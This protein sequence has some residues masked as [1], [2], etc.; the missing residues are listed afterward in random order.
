MLNSGEW[1]YE[2]PHSKQKH[3]RSLL[4]QPPQDV[5]AKAGLVVLLVLAKKE[6]MCQL[7]QDHRLL[8]FSAVEVAAPSSLL[9]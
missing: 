9:E 1:I 4:L 6:K 3:S 5:F 8:S 2:A 7:D